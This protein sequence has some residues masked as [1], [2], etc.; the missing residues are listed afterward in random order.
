VPVIW[1]MAS[2]NDSLRNLDVEVNG[3]AGEISF[4]PTGEKRRK[5][6]R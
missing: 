6:R 2:W 1:R 3:V 5:Y 4:R